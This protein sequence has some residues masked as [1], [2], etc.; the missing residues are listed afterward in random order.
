MDI[1][2]N[3]PHTQMP[4]MADPDGQTEMLV[5]QLFQL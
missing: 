1:V 5:D 4:G 3:P 2:E